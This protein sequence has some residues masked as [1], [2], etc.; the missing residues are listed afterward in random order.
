MELAEKPG[1]HIHQITRGNYGYLSKIREELDEAFDAE[2]QGCKLM[3]L[4]E[5]SDMIGA[6][7]GYLEKFHPGTSLQDLID[8]KNVTRRAFKN[9][10]R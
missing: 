8:M 6:V 10:I 3:C 7:E 1:Y 2:L 9:G 4:I 5:L